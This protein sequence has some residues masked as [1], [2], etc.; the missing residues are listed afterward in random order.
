LI[1]SRDGTKLTLISLDTGGERLRS[2]KVFCAPNLV[3][4]RLPQAGLHFLVE[5]CRKSQFFFRLSKEA[6]S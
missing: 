3:H 5:L 4:Q 2:D 6:D 1:E